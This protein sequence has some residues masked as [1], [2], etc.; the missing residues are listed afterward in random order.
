MGVPAGAAAGGNRSETGRLSP[1][2][3]QGGGSERRGGGGGL[4]SV[5]ADL[6][7]GSIRPV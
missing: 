5:H 3:V 1:R 6:K 4:V 7:S 2:R